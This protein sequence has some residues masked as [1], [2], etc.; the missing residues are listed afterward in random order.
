MAASVDDGE[1]VTRVLLVAMALS[2]CAE[3]RFEANGAR[4][5]ID[6]RACCAV[7]E[8]SSPERE[9]AAC[10]AR[11][12]LWQ[13]ALLCR[14]T[15]WESDEAEAAYD[16]SRAACHLACDCVCAADVEACSSVP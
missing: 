13:T 14:G 16:A 5:A 12:C 4:Y 9:A 11:G 7:P 8:G 3:T 1:V 10:E 2:A 6:R 15:D